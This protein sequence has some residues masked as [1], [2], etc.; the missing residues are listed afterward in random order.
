MKT[1][2]KLIFELKDGVYDSLLKDAASSDDITRQRGRLCDAISGFER[3]FGQ[4][5][6]SV[7]CA[8]FTIPL[9]GDF[10]EAQN[11]AV[12]SAA[13]NNELVVVIWSMCILKRKEYSS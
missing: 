5:E 13:I 9:L 3:D 8:P 6:V 12:L 10:T 4:M 1:T 2:N 7:Y 11:G